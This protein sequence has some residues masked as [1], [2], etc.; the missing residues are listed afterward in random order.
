MTTDFRIDWEAPS[1]S[2]W[3]FTTIPDCR[4]MDEALAAF[5]ECR[6]DPASRVPRDAQITRIGPA[7]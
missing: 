2:P 1:G 6:S 4:D 5:D 3:G 7:L